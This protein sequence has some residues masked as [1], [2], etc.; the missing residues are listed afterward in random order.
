MAVEHGRPVILT[1][2]VVAANEWANDLIGRPGVYVARGYDEALEHID[3]ALDKEA[4][5]S[6]VLRDLL[7][8]G[9]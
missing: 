1:D 2:Q 7:G 6:R 9:L 5:V 3:A 8:A 4:E